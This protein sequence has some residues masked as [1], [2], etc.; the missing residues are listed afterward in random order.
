M[1]SQNRVKEFREKLGLTQDQ[2]AKLVGTSQQQIQRIE[3]GINVPRRDTAFKVSTSLGQKMELVFPVLHKPTRKSSLMATTFPIRTGIVQPFAEFKW[4]MATKEPTQ[5]M[6]HPLYI[7]GAI[8]ILT[9]RNGEANN[10]KELRGDFS[11]L[12]Q[13]VAPMIAQQRA[14]AGER[15]KKP[16][17]LGSEPE[18]GRGK[19]RN[20]GQYWKAL[21]LTQGTPGVISVTKLG[22]G[23]ANGSI[24]TEEFAASTIRNFELPNPN[25]TDKDE[26]DQWRTAGIKLKPLTLILQVIVELYRMNPGEAY[27]N[28]EELCRVIIPLSSVNASASE[29]AYHVLTYRIDPTF[30]DSYDDFTPEDNDKR[31]AREFLRFLRLYGFLRLADGRLDTDLQQFWADDEHIELINMTLQMPIKAIS[32][33]EAAIEIAENG[34]IRTVIRERQTVNVISRPGQKKFRK[35]VLLACGYK[36]LLTDETVRDVLRAC[37]IRSVELNGTDDISNGLCFREDIHL[38]FDAGHLRIDAFGNVHL[39]ETA[40]R[41]PHYINLPKNIALPSHVS[42]AALDERFKTYG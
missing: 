7:V 8:R 36:C 24:S 37:H 40:K 35:E 25:A 27:L 14:L 1:S 26:L 12:D 34:D 4:R 18:Q 21:G 41:S 19:I 39:S 30:A 15:K 5:D 3:R 23:L 31:I 13:V 2:L 20:S 22:I 28:N 6:I 9:S 42:R 32:I 38:L 10:T 33:P 17:S 29:S 16:M 11:A